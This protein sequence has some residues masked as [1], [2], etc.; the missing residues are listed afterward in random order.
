[1]KN[2]LE[3]PVDL[4]LVNENKARLPALFHWCLFY[5]LSWSRLLG[6]AQGVMFMIFLGKDR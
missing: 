5:S 1:M 3:C 6:F 4:V 2:Y